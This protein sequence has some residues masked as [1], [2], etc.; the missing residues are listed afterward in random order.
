M[1]GDEPLVLQPV[2]GAKFGPPTGAHMLALQRA[3]MRH[4]ANTRVIPQTHR[5]LHVR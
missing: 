4:H 1:L 2:S 5:Q 3:A